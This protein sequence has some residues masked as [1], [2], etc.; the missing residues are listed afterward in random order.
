MSGFFS[1]LGATAT[2]LDAQ[3]QAIAV[4]SNN[5]ANVNNPNYSRETIAYNSLGAV[6]T[7]D[8]VQSVGLSV[9]VEQM[10][11]SVLDQMVQQEASLTSGFTSQQDVL[12]QAQAALGE[13]ITNSS[14]SATANS[15]TTTDSGL[16]AAINGFF[17]AVQSFASDPT[18][19]GQREAL[20]QQAGV[21][22]DRFQQ[23]DQNLSQV[24]AGADTEASS[25][26]D[27]A[28]TLLTDVAGLN[29]QIASVEVNS[30]GSAVNLRDQRE[31]DLEQ[32][33]GL[34]PITSVE[35]SKGEVTITTA[36]ATTGGSPPV[37]GPVTLVSN[38]S[39][40][41]ITY[42]S[43][44]LTT[45]AGSTLRT[46]TPA[47]GSIQGDVTA[48]TGAVQTLR[49]NLDALA[50]QLVTSVNAAYNPSSTSGG[51]FFDSSG[52]TAATIGLDSH[53]TNA[54]LTAGTGA[55][56]DNTIALAV[57]AVGNQ[58]F[59]TSG[60]DAIDGTVTQFYAN[61]VTGIGQAV[62]TANT[63]VTD[64]TNVQNI[65]MTQRN[66]LSGVS[67]NDEM[68]NLM[69]YQR[70]FQ[71]SSEVF[72]VINTLLDQLVTSLGTG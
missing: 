12:Q 38:G 26:V 10:R 40:T 56:G 29:T 34:L 25:G 70:A 30:P 35:N 19:N 31:A 48:G 8:G 22:T 39:A 57:A 16:E 67:L 18:D 9:S 1:A 69:S 11:S 68:T 65:V 5:I 43:G 20:L 15:S 60:G 50:N 59:A 53:L 49:D 6:A 46:L 14:T 72:N 13:S 24:Q 64:Q 51:N 21:L 42:T 55:A 33:A 7:P 28:N 37:S 27:T 32:L 47:S 4:T 23:I 3:T 2:A 63:R 44:V 45:G 36:A 66:S 41:A 58:V 62:D 71:A 17:G 61:A 54:T 52:T